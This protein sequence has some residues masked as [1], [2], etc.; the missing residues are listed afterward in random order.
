MALFE[1]VVGTLRYKARTGDRDVVVDGR[2][3]PERELTKRLGVS[4]R[5]LR[6]ALA[7]LEE[8]GMLSRQQGKGTFLRASGVGAADSAKLNSPAI[9][10]SISSSEDS[11]TLPAGSTIQISCRPVWAAVV[12]RICRSSTSPM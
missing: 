6:Q 10:W 3:L 9:D 12:C 5:K 7:L 1:D 4:R 8:E 2:L 11:A